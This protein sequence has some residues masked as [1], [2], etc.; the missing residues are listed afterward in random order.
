MSIR[1]LPAR[2]NLE[3]YKKRAKDLLKSWKSVE[4]AGTRKLADAQFDIAREHG[5][6]TWKAF[7]DEIAK[8][9]G[10]AEKAA[11]WKSAED[12][13]VAG[14]DVSLA[15]LLE[16]HGKMLRKERPQSSW[17]GGLTP[18]YKR[19]DAREIIA[20]E[21]CFENWEQFATFAAEMTQSH[22]QIA[23]FER[24]ADAVAFGDATALSH[25][26][27]D[28]PNLVRARSMRTHHSMLLHYVGANGVESW[29]QRPSKNAVHIAKILLDG[30][31]DIDAT[32]DMYKGG[33]TTLGLTATSIHPKNAGVLWE[34]IDLFLAR[35]A[36]IDVAG[37]GNAHAF[38]NGCLANGRP[39]AAQHLAER[40]APLDL[41]GAAGVGRLDVVRS[42]FNSDGTLKSA[43]MAAQMY[44][45]FNWAC[46]YGHLSVV[47]FLLDR[48]VSLSDARQIGV[49]WAAHGAHVE[50]LKRLLKRNPPLDAREKAFNATPLGWALHGWW[51]HR[52]QDEVALERYYEA[53]TLLVVAGATVDAGWLSGDNAITDSRMLKA[54]RSAGR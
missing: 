39:E 27:R 36:R 26:L 51:E 33:C 11:I 14:D 30:G 34:L 50:I 15:R 31:A 9:N 17:F 3:Q 2:P 21:H 47:E 46:E 24:A 38:V 35:G 22:S 41:E 20:R 49:Y 5:F 6:P 45:G 53:V 52:D 54:L 8:R 23:Q 13:L 7:T 16:A 25:A 32:A 12:A 29:R 48:G 10:A 43:A 18:D 40:G 4:P 42:F 19:G 28:N 44:A 37:A 1:E